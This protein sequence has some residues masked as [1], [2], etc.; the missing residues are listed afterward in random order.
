MVKLVKVEDE[1]GAITVSLSVHIKYGM[2]ITRQQ[3]ESGTDC[4]RHGKH[5]GIPA[6]S[7]Q[8]SCHRSIK[9]IIQKG[10]FVIDEK[11]LF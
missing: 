7:G 8:C 1:D 3:E 11:P 4:T 9:R 5:V 6:A 2:W 10:L